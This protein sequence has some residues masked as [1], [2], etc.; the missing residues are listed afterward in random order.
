MAMIRSNSSVSTIS[1][2]LNPLGGENEDVDGVERQGHQLSSLPPLVLI[3]SMVK[4]FTS[5]TKLANPGVAVID[6]NYQSTSLNRILQYIGDVLHDRKAYSICFVVHG[7][8]GNF[9]LVSEK[10]GDSSLPKHVQLM[11]L[12]SQQNVTL[13]AVKEDSEVKEFFTKMVSNFLYS[14]R[15]NDLNRIDILNCPVEENAE[16]KQMIQALSRL[17]GVPVFTSKVLKIAINF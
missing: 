5:L 1:N 13:A 7:L 16:G 12:V 11:Y 4:G 10:V 8:P 15:G 2:E 9:K 3:S 6:Y 14:D 17:I